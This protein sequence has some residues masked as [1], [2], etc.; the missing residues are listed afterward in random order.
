MANSKGTYLAGSTPASRKSKGFPLDSDGME[1]VR[2]R[3]PP[4]APLAS[5][6]QTGNSLPYFLA[7]LRLLNSYA[8]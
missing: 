4:V 3:T 2:K 7:N 6:V 5:S 8:V 1:K